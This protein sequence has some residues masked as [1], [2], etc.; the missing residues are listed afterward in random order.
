LEILIGD[1]MNQIYNT[2]HE[3]TTN[4]KNINDSSEMLE[5]VYRDLFLW[6]LLTHRIEMAKLFLTN[7]KTRICAALIVSKILKTYQ[8]YASDN[9]SKGILKTE[10]DDFESYAIECVRCCYNYDKLKACEII[11]RQ[12]KFFGSVT[13]LQVAIAADDKAF[14][15]EE[16][17][18]LLLTN[19]WFDK[20]DPVQTSTKEIIKI[21]ISLLTL[22][23]M[24]HSL[25]LFRTVETSDSKVSQPSLK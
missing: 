25:V 1:Y 8:S 6:A 9:D 11:I 15:H 19:I 10:A 18:H 24:A 16:T 21:F 22:G 23:M 20:I 5:Y 12:I 3:Q 17:C 4:P 14:V 13:C 7:M 2:L